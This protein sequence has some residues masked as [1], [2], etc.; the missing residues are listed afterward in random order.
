MNIVGEGG[1]ILG[2]SIGGNLGYSK[3]D[4]SH[5]RGDSG[6]SRGGSG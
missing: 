1:D 4:S 5:S 2:Y 3:G 6:H